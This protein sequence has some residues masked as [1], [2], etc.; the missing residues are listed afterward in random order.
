MSMTLRNVLPVLALACATA[1]CTPVLDWREVRPQGAGLVAL[2]PCK[3][4]GHSRQIVLAE[5]SVE[6]TLYACS[7]GGATYAVGFADLGRPQQVE[8][9]TLALADAAARNIGAPLP[10]D[11]VSAGV[12][13]MTP[14]TKARRLSL[15]G[16]LADGMPVQEQVVVFSRGTRVYQAT[17]IGAALSAD[18]LETFFDALRLPN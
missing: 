10:T 8:P 6:M 16:T 14:N 18:G 1:A 13:G 3:P 11:V 15:T 17:V 9:A 4:A 7:A 2:F 12:P 5:T